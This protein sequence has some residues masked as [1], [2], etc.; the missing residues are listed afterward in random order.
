MQILSVVIRG[1]Q[2]SMGSSQ[3]SIHTRFAT[4]TGNR[5]FQALQRVYT[6]T[7]KTI[8]AKEDGT[9]EV[10]LAIR[11]CL[12]NSTMP[13]QGNQHYLQYYLESGMITSFLGKNYQHRAFSTDGAASGALGRPVV[14][15]AKTVTG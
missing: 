9:K 13:K 10:S 15:G 8:A 3:S 14:H 7:H 4:G 6:S 1:R 11:H 12:E 5:N 2:L